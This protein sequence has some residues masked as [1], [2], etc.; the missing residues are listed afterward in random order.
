MAKY[1]YVDGKFKNIHKANK[2]FW[3]KYDKNSNLKVKNYMK[4][5]RKT[6]EYYENGN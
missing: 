5:E 3:W 6:I 4:G 2:N 1:T